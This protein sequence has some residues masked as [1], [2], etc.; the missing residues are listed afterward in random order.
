MSIYHQIL[1]KYW[2]FDNFR[3]LQEDI[4]LSISAGNDTLGLMPTG[5]GKSITF[6][7]PALAKKGLCLVITPL[8]SLMKDQ[9][10][11]LA[12]RKIKAVAIYSGMTYREIDIALNN[13]VYDE[14]IKFLYISPERLET[15]LFITRVQS[16]PVNLIAVDESHCISQWGYDFRPS[17]L[18]IADIR[19]YL[20]EVPVLALTATATPDVVVDIQEKLLFKKPNV[21]KKSFER[22]NL[23]YLVRNVENKFDYLIKSIKKVDGSGIVYVRS[24]RQTKE[25]CEV[26][27]KNNI[28]A[29]YYHA[30]LS[31]KLRSYKQSLWKNGNKQVIV[32]TNAFGMGI[33]KPDVRFVVHFDIPENIESYYQEAGRAGRDEKE[34]YAVLAYNQADVIK[35]KNNFE[36]SFPD[37]K[38][39]RQV[40]NAMCNYLRLPVGSGKGETY[41]FNLYDFAKSYNY[42]LQIAYNALRILERDHYIV[43]TDIIDHPS[44]I[45]ILVSNDELYN[46]RLKKPKYDAFIKMILRSYSGLFQDYVRIDENF[47]SKHTGLKEDAVVDYLKALQTYKVID[48]IIK[49][50]ASYIVMTE[51]RLPEKSITISK[52][53]YDFRKKI[54]ENKYKAMLQYVTSNDK[55]RSMLLLEYF[56]QK[57]PPACGHC[58]V[59]LKKSVNTLNNNEF[60]I[61]SKEILD[62]LKD[63]PLNPLKITQELNFDDKKI[64]KTIKLL[65]DRNKIKY[66][67]NNNLTLK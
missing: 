19:Q 41:E 30:G 24:R 9:V 4:I 53:N 17:Y 59:C 20:P 44:R 37:I 25:I 65:L 26:L 14:S 21:F 48:Y 58:D 18:K 36:N 22:K 50:K 43:L 40:Y 67:N 3:P 32:A 33:D 64:I 5:G 6:Q 42:N 62:L 12:K 13:C 66:D 15:E 7:V 51:E 27:Q 61:I 8:I 31:P 29:D 63:N 57:D 38:T 34:A 11:N 45:K 1:K 60:E 28:S 10:D 52:E 56:G 2:G 49:N 55:C 46:F 16:M 39:I 47:I 54:S 35:L 23:I